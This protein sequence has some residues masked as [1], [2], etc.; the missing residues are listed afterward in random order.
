MF[1]TASSVQDLNR[2]ICTIAEPDDV[3]PWRGVFVNSLRKVRRF[4]I[5][6]SPAH[7]NRSFCR[8]QDVKEFN[9]RDYK[10]LSRNMSDS[11]LEIYVSMSDSN[12]YVTHELVVV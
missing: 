12:S 8:S 1:S 5:E 9:R 4:L 2:S 6:S 3:E 10:S 7:V 11:C